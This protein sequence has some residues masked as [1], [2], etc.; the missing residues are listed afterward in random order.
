MARPSIETLNPRQI[1]AQSS[2][3]NE[4]EV[5]MRVA[6]QPELA[7]RNLEHYYNQLLSGA[8]GYIDHHEAR[9]VLGI[10]DY[11]ELPDRYMTIGEEALHH[12]VLLKL[13]GGL[14]TGMGMNGPKSLLPVKGE[15]TFLDVIIRQILHLRAATGVRLP[16]VLMNSFNTRD[17]T[18]EALTEYPDFSQDI[19]L[20]FLQHKKPKIWKDSLRP[21]VWPS[22]PSKEWCPPGHGDIYVSF[23]TTGMLDLMLQAGYEYLFVSNSD[24]LGA[25]LDKK[26]LGYFAEQRL[27]FLMEVANRTPA[28]NKGGHLSRRPNGQLMLRELSQCPPE[29]IEQ[30][31]DINRYRFF[32]TNNL[33]LHL[34]SLRKVLDEHGDILDLPLIR[35]EKPIDP[36]EPSSPRVYQLETAMGSAIALFEG[37]QALRVPRARFVPVKRNSDLLAVWSDVYELTPDYR[38]RLSPARHTFPPRRPPLVSLDER[39]YTLIADMQERFPYG[40]PSMI[41]CTELR[42]EGDVYFGKEVVLEGAVTIVN[43]GDAPLCIPDGSRITGD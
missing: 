5:R 32:N 26:I 37:A 13:N 27:P 8:T 7:I 12:T 31:Q 42:V 10:P 40:P 33:W 19:P 29:E 23:V 34:P 22:D 41:Q 15:L 24:N 43:D 21:A 4:F 20:D 36:S 11:E 16:L 3:F 6:G 17:A 39:Y 14:G 2:Y 35:N 18:L 9:P 28:D 1:S 25:V 30:F 38:L